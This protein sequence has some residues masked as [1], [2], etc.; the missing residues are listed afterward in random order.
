MEVYSM[1]D[2]QGKGK[3]PGKT[4]GGEAAAGKGEGDEGS[5]ALNAIPELMR[6]AFSL[7]FSGF[8]L[9]ETAVR[10]ALGDAMPQDWIDF[11]VE[12]SERTRAEF[13]ERLT[14]EVARSLEAVDLGAVLAE[15]LEGRTLEIKAE[16]RLGAKEDAAGVAIATSRRPEG[17]A[18]EDSVLAAAAVA[19]W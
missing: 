13:I 17:E 14:F 9:T 5:G 16:I 12:Q 6:K 3:K 1:A 11:A 19:T 2:E 7:G 15:L 4:S 10:K 8:F 18:R